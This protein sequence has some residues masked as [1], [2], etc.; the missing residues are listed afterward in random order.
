M[1]SVKPQGDSLIIRDLA[2]AYHHRMVTDGFHTVLASIPQR[3]HAT[4]ERFQLYSAWAWV[5]E[6]SFFEL[7]KTSILLDNLE[8]KIWACRGV[9]DYP[10]NEAV[11]T[12]KLFWWVKYLWP[13]IHA[14]LVKQFAQA[15]S[16]VKFW[17]KKKKMQKDK[18]NTVLYMV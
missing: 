1:P 3:C 11:G 10:A 15:I 14:D 5:S 6:W 2:G 17:I 16:E 18:Y 8:E 9:I 7:W 12:Q 13:N 4:E